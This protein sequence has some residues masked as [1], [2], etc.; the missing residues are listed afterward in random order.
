[1]SDSTTTVTPAEKEQN[2][3]IG[4]AIA[5]AFVGTSY[6]LV[7]RGIDRRVAKQI[8]RHIRKEH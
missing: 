3:I 1:M 7:R 8:R 4:V 6:Y 5:A 2:V